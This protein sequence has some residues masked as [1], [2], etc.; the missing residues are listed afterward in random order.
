MNNFEKTLEVLS[1]ETFKHPDNLPWGQSYQLRFAHELINGTTVQID[2][3]H[4]KYG[5]VESFINKND[6]GYMYKVRGTGFKKKDPSKKA[7]D[8]PK[9]LFTW[10]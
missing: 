7:K 10:K 5:Y 3:P 1:E 6:R 2:G 9:I 4:D 8:I